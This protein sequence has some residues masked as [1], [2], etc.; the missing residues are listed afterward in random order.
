MNQTS[1]PKKPISRLRKGAIAVAIY[2]TTFGVAKCAGDA[3][4]LSG[5]PAIGDPGQLLAAALYMAIALCPAI[6][7]TV[8][9]KRRTAAQTAQP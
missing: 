9:A 5:S 2:A 8:M 4:G 3:L 7:Y 1:S 6:F